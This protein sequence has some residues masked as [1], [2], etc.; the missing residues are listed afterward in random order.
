MRQYISPN[1]IAIALMYS[2]LDLLQSFDV[3]WFVV[4]KPQV[5][6]HQIRFLF[7][8]MVVSYWNMQWPCLIRNNYGVHSWEKGRVKRKECKVLLCE[9]KSFSGTMEFRN[10]DTITIDALLFKSCHYFF[11]FALRFLVAHYNYRILWT[12]SI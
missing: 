2:S 12:W 11:F 8:N 5:T 10:Y 3:M 6:S 7:Y 9:W 4:S 1:V